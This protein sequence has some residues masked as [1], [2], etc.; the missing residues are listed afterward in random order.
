MTVSYE[1]YVDVWALGED[2]AVYKAKRELTRPG[3]AFSDWAPF[4]FT[5]KEVK[6]VFE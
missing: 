3:G 1:G 5:A 6:R 2:D 4:M